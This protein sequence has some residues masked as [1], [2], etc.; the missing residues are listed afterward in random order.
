MASAVP[1]SGRERPVTVKEDRAS[2]E[3]IGHAASWALGRLRGLRPRG[4]AVAAALLLAVLVAGLW[5]LL[6]DGEAGALRPVADAP[7]A[8]ADVAAARRAL[9][10]AGLPVRIC[11]GRLAVPADLLPAA[12]RVLGERGIPRRDPMAELEEVVAATDVLST[13]AGSERRW[14]VRLM[15]VLGRLI[16]TFPDVRSAT[17]L[18]APGG[19]KRIAQPARR[20][21]ASVHVEL[22]PDS[23]MTPGLLQAIAD[24]V[25][26]AVGEL[27]AADVRV[28]DSRGRSYCPGR[29]SPEALSARQAAQCAEAELRAAAR[30]AL[31]DARAR[32]VEIGRAS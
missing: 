3:R 30:E 27:T 7:L 1:R 26:G 11:Q 9:Q 16:E 14:R 29:T 2:M 5:G 21:G 6:R 8:A 31:P 17:V 13:Q 15:A 23:E 32:I 18:L 22:E 24:Q 19:Q 12:R 28:V 25:C 4:R 10:D 20:P